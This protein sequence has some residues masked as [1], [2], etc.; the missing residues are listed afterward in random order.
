MNKTN[1]NLHIPVMLQ[2]TIEA[3]NINPQGIYVDCTA[4]LGGH[5]SKILAQLNSNGKLICIDQDKTAIDYLQKIFGNDSR[6]IVIHDNFRHLKLILNT[7]K[8]AKVDGILV[9]LGVSSPMFDD[10]TRGF[11]YH[12]EARLDMRMDQDQKLDAHFIVNK[13]DAKQLNTIFKLYGE[14][15]NSKKVTDA[16]CEARKYKTINT[17]TELVNII[18]DALPPMKL[19][20]KKHPARNYFQA[21]RIAVNDE[22][23]ALRKLLTDAFDLLKLHGRIVAIAF[24]SLEDRIVKQTFNKHTTSQIPKEVPIINEVINYKLINKKPIN[25][26]EQEININ[27]RSRSAKLRIIEKI[28]E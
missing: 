10:P 17:T 14:I 1:N 3:L 12:S 24:H 18:K 27:R 5:S 28:K 6:V 8:I 9:D 16:I 15:Y 13:Y 26:T 2:E 22:L 11:S 19:Y 23:S 7:L 20:E 25:A 21:I 4:G